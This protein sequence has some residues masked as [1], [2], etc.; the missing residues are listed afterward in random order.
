MAL[1]FDEA[2]KNSTDTFGKGQPEAVPVYE[3]EAVAGDPISLEACM[4]HIFRQAKAIRDLRLHVI[5]PPE[6]RM[7]N[8]LRRACRIQYRR[9]LFL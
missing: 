6:R 5:F 4:A 2:P 3:D 1:R 7:M 9:R 8:S